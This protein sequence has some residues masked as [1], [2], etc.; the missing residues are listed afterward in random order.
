M[1]EVWIGR[2]FAAAVVALDAM[3]GDHHHGR[4]AWEQE[5]VDRLV[6]DVARTAADLDLPI[7]EPGQP[8]QEL[9]QFCRLYVGEPLR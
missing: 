6:A 3:Q 2:E 5:D 9:R 7:K 8:S 4:K 1:S